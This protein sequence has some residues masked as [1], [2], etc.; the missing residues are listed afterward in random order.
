MV[1]IA[2]FGILF[3][4]L[5]IAEDLQHMG[6]NNAHPGQPNQ[7]PMM[8]S[9]P[10]MNPLG[11]NIQGA[12]GLVAQNLALAQGAG[13]MNQHSMQNGLMNPSSAMSGP[14]IPVADTLAGPE[15]VQKLEQ[16]VSTAVEAEKPLLQKGVELFRQKPRVQAFTSVSSLLLS[17][18]F[19]L[20]SLLFIIFSLPKKLKKAS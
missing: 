8:S 15:K 2:A 3:I 19:D 18:S 16:S 1:F 4:S 11:G 12:P 9:L 7:F 13:S 14:S 5:V 17:F 20:N 6:M 10:T